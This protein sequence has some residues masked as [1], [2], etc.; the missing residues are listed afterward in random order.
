MYIV[1]FLL[2]EAALREQKWQEATSELR[3][4]LELN[5]TFDQAMMGLARA[6]IFENNTDEAKQWIQR[7]LSLNPQNYRAW[8]QLGFIESLT[9]SNAALQNYQKALTIQDN[10]APL[11]KDLGMLLYRTRDYQNAA[12]HLARATELGVKDAEVYNALGICYRHLR[13][14]TA[15]TAAYKN[16]LQLDP[17]M[18][19]AHLNLAYVYQLTGK[20]LLS[21]SEYDTACQL[22]TSLCKYRPAD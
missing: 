8:Y 10:F 11:R 1:P 21:K 3:K 22:D 14:F 13:K 15:A 6:L 12:K 2:G 16:A 9:D 17:S 18:A 20:A 4:C 5:P 19:Q 7:A